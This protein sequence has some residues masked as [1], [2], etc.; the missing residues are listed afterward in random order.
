MVSSSNSGA[1]IGFQKIF[2]L[3]KCFVHEIC[4]S[5]TQNGADLGKQAPLWPT[6]LCFAYLLLEQNKSSIA[7]WNTIKVFIALLIFNVRSL[8]KTKSTYS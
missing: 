6:P 3:Q 8:D 7:S 1:F 2:E 4:I 5:W